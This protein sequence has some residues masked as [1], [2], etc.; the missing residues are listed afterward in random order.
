METPN[1][2]REKIADKAAK[3]SDFRALLL[4][5]PKGAL[6]Q[7][8][9]VTIP[10]ALSVE[11]HEESN[12]TTHL[13]LPPRQQAERHRPAGGRR[14]RPGLGVLPER[15]EGLVGRQSTGRAAA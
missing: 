3:D 15:D 7:E 9:G 12:T 8:L 6:K 1:E 4:R 2:L 13:V 11:V 5:D 14:R 10:E